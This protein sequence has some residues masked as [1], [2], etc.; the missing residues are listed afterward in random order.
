MFLQYK[1]AVKVDFLNQ[2]VYVKEGSVLEKYPIAFTPTLPDATLASSFNVLLIGETAENAIA[3]LY[4]NTLY[5]EKRDKNEFSIS[6]AV[7]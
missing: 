7:L 2:V 6:Q 3:I 1:P 4:A 5:G